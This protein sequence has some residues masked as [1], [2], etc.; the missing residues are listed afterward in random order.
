MS[1]GRLIVLEGTDGSG[2]GTQF[3]KLTERLKLEGYDIE[4]FDFP[5]YQSGSSYFIRQYLNGNYGS[6]DAVG[7][8]AASMFFALDRYEAAP[9]IKSALENGK[10]VICNRYTGSNMGHQ[11]AKFE[12]IQERQGFY[13]WLDNL[14]YE[15]F[16]IPRPSVNIIL[17]VPA[18]VAQS[19][20]DKK[21][22]RDY[23]DKKRDIHEADLRHL[24]KAVSVY[25]ELAQ[26]FPKD[27]TLLDCTQ[28]GALLDIATISQKVWELILPFL[29]DKSKKEE[30]MSSPEQLPQPPY[31]NKSSAGIFEI[32]QSG[33][34]F[35]EE[36]VTDTE[37]DVYAF[38]DSKLGAATIA[39]AMARLSRRSD[40][41]R[42]T[43][44]DEFAGKEG[45]DEQLLD[46]VITAYGDDSVQQLVGQ[47]LVVE[48]ASN[49]LTKQLE[50]GRLASYL[51]QST[52]YIY[53]D[54]PDKEGKYKYFRPQNLDHKTS[55]KYATSMDSIF[56]I[57]SSLVHEMTEYFSS[58]ST[59][60]QQKR[61]A[62]WR[63]A[64]RAQACDAVRPLLPV[65][66][67]STVGIF[68]SGQAL[69]GLIMRLR[70]SDSDE[71]RMTGEK[72][73]NETRK[74]IPTFLR[75]ADNP[76]KGGAMSMYLAETSQRVEE[77][78]KRYLPEH[79]SGEAKD[80]RLLSVNPSNELDLVPFMLYDKSNLPFEEIRAA[81]DTWPI[82]RKIEV[83]QAYMGTRLNRRQKPGRALEHAMYT[84]DLMCDYGIFR[85]LQRHRMVNDL[86]WQSLTPRYG[87]DIPESIEEAGLADQFE[88]CFAI[89]TQLF[90]DLQAAGYD[91]E[92]QYATL[93]GHK[94]RWTVSYN[95]REAFHLHE[96]RTTPQGHPGYRKLIRAM[97]EIVS[98]HHPLLAEAMI[99]VN[100]DE[101]PE[102]TRLAAE[103]YTQSKLS[104]I[105]K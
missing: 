31:L 3:A 56:G 34:Q 59:E 17:K 47:H 18:A 11:G 83:F 23:T 99:F 91:Y 85:D 16:G 13:L 81:V 7:P 19:L 89:A 98:E 86:R 43:I 49:L 52:R 40:D 102:L 45:K 21:A 20:V 14:E 105:N 66:T 65:A 58:I 44:L 76:A 54:Q 84:W 88:R 94:M 35:L 57:Y 68:A 82:E 32:T 9:K 55:E 67:K 12:N 61:D 36:V 22:P 6:A 39:A 27:F 41:M 87:F 90:S 96:L 70:A 100:K 79:Y 24:E 64:I 37:G 30:S 97:H 1:T 26:L 8:F 73:L 60:P 4:T 28:D 42:I 50:W 25:D 2:K 103:R 69:E 15:V 63:S 93:L 48:G 53:F 33:R 77:L 71:A 104:Q 51:E 10:V 72:I 92:A 46:R 5:Q 78:G 29:P 80:V 62:A 101:D 74:V 38:R 75:R 95:A